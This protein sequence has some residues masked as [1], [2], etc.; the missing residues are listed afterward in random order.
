MLLVKV[1]KF[2]ALNSDSKLILPFHAT[3][4]SNMV[5]MIAMAC[6]LLIENGNHHENYHL[7]IFYQSISLML[8]RDTSHNTS[9]IIAIIA[10]LN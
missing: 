4:L 5:T 8:A 2:L 1:L 7:P 10:C 9:Y 3:Q 6:S